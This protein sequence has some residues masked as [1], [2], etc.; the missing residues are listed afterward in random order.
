MNTKTAKQWF[1]SPMSVL[2]STL[3]VL[4][5]CTGFQVK[6]NPVGAQV[7]MD[8]TETGKVTPA[9]LLIRDIPRGQHTITVQKE[10]FDTVTP[11][12]EL[13][14]KTHPGTI[15]ASIVMSL[16]ATPLI[17]I[18]VACDTQF[19]GVYSQPDV[20]RKPPFELV[21]KKAPVQAAPKDNLKPEGSATPQISPPDTNP[22]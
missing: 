18:G 4:C 14:V 17:I 12:W 9:K 1:V 22:Q 8:G 21:P 6:S 15:V 2:L 7:I 13:V 3:L 11:P 20:H 16:V 19:K 10:G 5:G